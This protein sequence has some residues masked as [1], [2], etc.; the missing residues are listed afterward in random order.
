MGEEEEEEE[1]QERVNVSRRPSIRQRLKSTLSI[2]K[3]K[4]HELQSNTKKQQNRQH[5]TE[6]EALHTLHSEL[7]RLDIHIPPDMIYAG[8]LEA[9]LLRFLRARKCNI[10]KTVEMLSAAIKWRQDENVGSVLE[11]SL[12]SWKA[13]VI[14]KYKPSSYVSFDR[15]GRPI[16]VDRIGLLNQIGLREEGVVEDD[17]V[18]FHVREMEYM[19]RI[20]LREAS[21][22]QGHTIDQIIMIMDVGGVSIKHFTKSVREIFKR[23]VHIDQNNY[24]ETNGGTY[25]VNAGTVFSTIW[26]VLE[27][28][29][30]KKTRSKISVLGSGKRMLSV[31]KENFDPETLPDFLGGTLDFDKCRQTWATKM[32]QSIQDYL[33][34]QE[35]VPISSQT[36]GQHLPQL[37]LEFLSKQNQDEDD[38]S[39]D[40]FFTPRSALSSVSG[41]SF[42]I[43]DQLEDDMLSRR[44]SN[45]HPHPHHHS[46][47]HPHHCHNHNDIHHN[48]HH[49][50]GSSSSSNN[51]NG[52]NHHCFKHSHHH[53]EH[54]NP[55]SVVSNVHGHLDSN[56]NGMLTHHLE[57]IDEDKTIKSR[58][59]WGRLFTCSKG[60][61]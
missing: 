39:E 1:E 14:R 55:A 6:I 15:L 19:G 21:E 23:Q 43:I 45:L 10:E 35:G 28:F 41:I 29:L 56:H 37:T 17:I 27:P 22:T 8:D 50:H 60:K 4:P 32:D 54:S 48:H 16:Y 30:D 13:E 12:P 26:R 38:D 58:S 40:S 31:L 53:C 9:T 57:T 2:N 25:I 36:K 44:L 61:Q 24:P 52:N 3:S 59:C 49:N 42:G 7:Y 34:A 18:Q 46:D 20:L 5:D 47:Q 33:L 51:H 11:N